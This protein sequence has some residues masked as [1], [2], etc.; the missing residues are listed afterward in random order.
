MYAIRIIKQIETTTLH[1]PE[2]EPFVGRRVEIIVL[3]DEPRQPHVVV[4][5]GLLAASE[6]PAGDPVAD[7][8]AELR[9]ERERRIT[10]A[11]DNTVQ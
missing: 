8:L 9:A 6:A 1:V 2:L 4:T 3:D 7:A 5:R 11:A 10:D